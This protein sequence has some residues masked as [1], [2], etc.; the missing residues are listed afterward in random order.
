MKGLGLPWGQYLQGN[1]TVWGA[2]NLKTHHYI[3]T[4]IV[5]NSIPQYPAM[6]FPSLAKEAPDPAGAKMEVQRSAFAPAASAVAWMQHVSS[7][8]SG[9]S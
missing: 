2:A 5:E 6:L 3:P 7:S 1:H 4:S 9:S 8:N